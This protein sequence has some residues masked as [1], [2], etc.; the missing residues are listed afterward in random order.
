MNKLEFCVIGGDRRQLCL[1]DY[2]KRNYYNVKL[3]AFSEQS[4]DI[5]A[6][7]AF[8]SEQQ[9][10]GATVKILPLPVSKDGE[11]LNAP[12]Y[13]KT[14]YLESIL[15]Y[16][17][18]GD[19]VFGGMIPEEF[20]NKAISRGARVTDYYEDE[21][22]QMLNAVPTAEGVV[23]IL[24]DTLPVTL[25]GLNTAVLGYGKTGRVIAKTL[26]AL[27]SD[28]SVF[29]RSRGQLGEIT[30]LGYTPCRYEALK[31]EPVLFDALINTVPAHVL[32]KAELDNLNRDCLIIEIASAPF[33]TD[34]EYAR[35]KGFK[36]IKA[37]SLPGTIAPKTAGEII[38][39]TIL[40]SVSALRGDE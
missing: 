10:N 2:L 36:V 23:K 33:G 32:G 35:E 4:A 14:V 27:G 11:T 34:F 17:K 29:A 8:A 38:G 31:T 3:S 24:I 28:V 18:P 37:G 5:P 12:L 16:L 40:T 26:A 39:K 6:A 30:A 1:A 25:K 19:L 20:R 21:Y 13:D 22:L 7:L 15:S 9:Q